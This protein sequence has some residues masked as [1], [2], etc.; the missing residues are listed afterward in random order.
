MIGRVGDDAFA[1]RLVDNLRRDD[2]QVDAVQRL[3]ECSSGIAVV[4]VESSGENSIIV[5]PGANGRLSP[6]DLN[7]VADL[8]TQADQLVMQLEIP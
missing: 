8:I 7:D 6:D 2:V 3:S 5:V 4:S 1:N